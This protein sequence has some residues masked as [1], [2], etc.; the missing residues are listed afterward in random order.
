MDVSDFNK[1]EFSS[2]DDGQ[3]II[4]VEMGGLSK[5]YQKL[6]EENVRCS[7]RISGMTCASCVNSIEKHLA[8]QKG[9]DM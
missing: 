2:G 7:L 4:V 5:G 9:E 3:D 8:K 1:S 6:G